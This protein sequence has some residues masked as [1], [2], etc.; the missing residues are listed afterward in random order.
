MKIY[1]TR[2]DYLTKS[3]FWEND[4]LSKKEQPN[5]D[6]SDKPYEMFTEASL[7]AEGGCKKRKRA[8][9]WWSI[10][11]SKAKIA[12]DTLKLHLSSLWYRLL[13]GKDTTQYG[14]TVVYPDNIMST[15]KKLQETH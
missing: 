6:L 15:N 1:V 11:I 2:W 12:V 14:T 10:P 7:D 13:D 4:K 5:H 3:T 9:T 8:R